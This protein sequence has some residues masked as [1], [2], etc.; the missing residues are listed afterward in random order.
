[1]SS[2]RFEEKGTLEELRARM[3]SARAENQRRRNLRRTLLLAG[4]AAAL[5]GLG[6]GALTQWGLVY[7]CGLGV[8]AALLI[9][10]RVLGSGV[11][12]A[13]RLD[14]VETVLRGARFSG[15]VDVKVWLGPLLGGQRRWLE[16][17]GP[18]PSGAEFGMFLEKLHKTETT[19]HARSRVRTTTT[20]EWVGIRL[21]F[22][23]GAAD[24]RAIAKEGAQKLADAYKA[25]VHEHVLEPGRLTLVLQAQ[26]V[27]PLMAITLGQKYHDAL[28]PKVAAFDR[29]AGKVR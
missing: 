21:A 22:D 7:G 16:V 27:T 1:M 23:P 4:A 11:N 3:S 8:A 19:H 13:E 14:D 25:G 2:N 29:Q 17:S 20:A 15:P 10:G 18:L 28:F 9:A 5:A 26:K 24:V 6:A 12:A